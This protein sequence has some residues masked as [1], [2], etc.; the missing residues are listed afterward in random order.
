MRSTEQRNAIIAHFSPPFAEDNFLTQTELDYLVALFNEARDKIHKNTGPVTLNITHEMWS[1]PV[2]SSIRDKLHGIIGEFDIF[3]AFFF[4][5]ETPHIIH[6][7]DSFDLPET[8]KGITLPLQITHQDGFKG[9]PEL[10]F[11]NQYY[12]EGPSKFFNG[13]TTSTIYH[14]Q[15]VYSYDAVQGTT[16]E[17]FNEQLRL[18]YFSHLKP[19]WLKGLSFDRAMKWTPGRAIIFDSVRLHCASNFRAHGIKSKLG[20]SIFTYKR[21]ID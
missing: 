4:Y 8:Y 13:D 11:F 19:S 12:L 17:P 16:E 3:A 10:C 7:D 14:N 9:E 1:D 18:R 20:L 6:N 5:V 15:P 2:L 21:N